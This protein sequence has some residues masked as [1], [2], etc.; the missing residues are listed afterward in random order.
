MLGLVLSQYRGNKTRAQ[1][2]ARSGNAAGTCGAQ[3]EPKAQR[4]CNQLLSSCQVCA[5]GLLTFPGAWGQEEGLDD[6]RVGKGL[7][8]TVSWK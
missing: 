7:Q 1:D 5:H 2:T 3:Q 6:N 4:E 8:G